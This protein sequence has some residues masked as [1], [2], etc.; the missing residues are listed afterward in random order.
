MEDL[1]LGE[2]KITVN[3]AQTPVQFRWSGTSAAQN[4][5]DAVW[6]V[7][8]RV[9]NKCLEQ[10]QPIEMDVCELAYFNSA[11]VSCFVDTISQAQLRGVKLAMIY[12]PDKR[13]QR[14]CFQAL[15]G[16]IEPVGSVVLKQR[17]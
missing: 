3:D 16:V 9:L 7:I 8:S 12:D 17:P 4:P 15:S 10:N 2:L 11:T 5:K 6:P 13:S 1:V 14:I